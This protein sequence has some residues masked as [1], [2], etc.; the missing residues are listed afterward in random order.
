MGARRIAAPGPFGCSHLTL[1]P[2]PENTGFEDAFISARRTGL[3]NALHGSI[4]LKTY[5]SLLRTHAPLMIGSR[6]WERV[7]PRR[8]SGL[9]RSA[10][11]TSGGHC[12]YQYRSKSVHD[13]TLSITCGNLQYNKCEHEVKSGTAVKN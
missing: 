2:K 13:R 9:L 5:L 7:G 3:V 6:R 12:A 8:Q 4:F 11:K 1:P 10:H